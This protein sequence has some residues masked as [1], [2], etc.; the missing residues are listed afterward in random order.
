MKMTETR[1]KAL[2]YSR[3][4]LNNKIDT[5]ETFL[6]PESFVIAL[7][8]ASTISVIMTLNYLAKRS[9]KR[10][11]VA[12]AIRLEAIA[13]KK[14]NERKELMEKINAA[15]EVVNN[16]NGNVWEEILFLDYHGYIQKLPE[17]QSKVL[18]SRLADLISISKTK[19]QIFFN[20]KIQKALGLIEKIV[21]SSFDDTTIK[22]GIKQVMVLLDQTEEYK[23][24]TG[25]NA[26]TS[27]IINNCKTIVKLSDS[28]KQKN[29]KST[30]GL[31]IIL[32]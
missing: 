10:L 28:L 22:I 7:M 29:P 32:N 31:K 2:E 11:A 17:M 23:S 30:P 16:S 15:I 12:E 13:A 21:A 1:L 25:Y 9:K 4:F 24:F 20:D 14:E 18:K 8:I 6:T 3:K 27:K 26:L 19:Q 5:M